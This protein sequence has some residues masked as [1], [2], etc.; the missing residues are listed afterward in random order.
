MESFI[1]WGSGMATTCMGGSRRKRTGSVD[2][3]PS[4]ENHTSLKVSLE[5]QEGPRKKQLDSCQG[6]VRLSVK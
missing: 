5:T 4:L 1:T 3:P 6:S 2:P